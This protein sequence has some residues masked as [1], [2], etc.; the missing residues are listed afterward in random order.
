MN[1]LIRLQRAY[2]IIGW[3]RTTSP[4]SGQ[5]FS[6]KTCKAVASWFYPITEAQHA[7]HIK[8]VNAG[9]WEGK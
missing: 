9:I 6:Y 3:W 5:V 8:L 1:L 2:F 4:I 7:M